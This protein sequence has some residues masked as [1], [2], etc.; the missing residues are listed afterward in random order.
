MVESGNTETAVQV[1]GLMQERQAAKVLP[2]LPEAMASQL[3][4]KMKYLK[5]TP[6]PGA[7]APPPE[8]PPGP[9]LPPPTPDK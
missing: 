4:E 2:E 1:L 7:E 5:K 6:A 9:D 3:M 8:A